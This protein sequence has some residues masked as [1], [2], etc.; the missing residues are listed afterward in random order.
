MLLLPGP[1][2]TNLPS[3]SFFVESHLRT[4]AVFRQCLRLLSHSPALSCINVDQN[5]RISPFINYSTAT[6]LFSEETCIHFLSFCKSMTS[7]KLGTCVHSPIIK[8]GLDR[9]LHICNNLL[10]FYSKHGQANI[11]HKL[12][13]EMRY[14]DIVSWTATISAFVQSGNDEEALW[15]YQQMLLVGLVPNHFT[16]S[17]IMRCAAS[18]R[19]LD[20]GMSHHAVILKRGFRSNYV[21]EGVL[22]DFYFKCGMFDDACLIFEL[23]TDRDTV[24]WTTMISALVQAE[25]WN[26]TVG[27]Y[28]AMLR[29]GVFPNEFTFSKLLTA[30]CNLDSRLGELVHAHVILLGIELNLAV[31]T[32]L[33]NMYSKCSNMINATKTLHLTSDFDTLLWTAIIS[34]YARAGDCS[35]AVAS[36]QEMQTSAAFPPNTFTYTALLNASSLWTLPELGKVF[37]CLVV[38]AGIVHDVSVGNAIVDLYSKCSPQLEDAMN[39]FEEISSPNVVSWTALISGLVRHGE[40]SAA[41][42]ALTEMQAAGVKPNSFTLSTILTDLSSAEGPAHAQKL[43]TVALKTNLDTRDITVGNS[44]VA[45]YAK[46][47]RPIDAGKVFDD[48]SHR[49]VCTYTS[50]AKG[51]NQAGLHGQVLSLIRPMRAELTSIDGFSIAS[52]LS[53]AAGLCAAKC[54]RQLHCYSLKSGLSVSISV[55]NGLVDMYSKCGCIAEARAIFASIQQ[56]NVVSWNGLMSGLASNGCF[57]NALSALEDMIMAGVLPDSVTFLIA[58][59]ACSHGGLVDLGMDYFNSMEEQFGLVPGEDH[60]VCLVD[61]LGRAGRLEAA[62]EAIETMVHQPRALIFKTL[63]GCCRLHGNVAMGE[64]AASQAMELDPLDSAVYVLLAGMYDDAGRV[65]FGEEIRKMMRARGATKSPGRS[66]M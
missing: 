25:D 6:V 11:A 62:A 46:L 40:D 16:L 2:N 57:A 61:M 38:K 32:A 60:Y 30:C 64:W 66:W 49:D 7:S 26:K 65:E 56:P 54:G 1:L 19:D 20:L 41:M 53:A 36:F 15:L 17:S 10:S 39:A 23:M 18:V 14:R 35:R 3:L 45:A 47:G 27:I 9:H 63:L 13:E 44:L 5:S 52:F 4:S 43:H 37:H 34:G 29:D 21:L 48:V 42:E 31:K 28:I 24:S 50:L 55:L 58:L 8:L 59:Y 12:F 22:L 51:L 33:V